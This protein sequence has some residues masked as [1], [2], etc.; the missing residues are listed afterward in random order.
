MVQNKGLNR[1]YSLKEKETKAILK[2]AST[3]LGKINLTSFIK[4]LEIARISSEDEVYILDG[5]PVFIGSKGEVLP[6]LLNKEILSKLPTITVDMGAVPYLCNG[7]DLMAPGIVKI[8]GEFQV[9]ALVV[10]VDENFS[11]PLALVK[12]LYNVDEIL[13]KKQ[14]KVARNIHFVGDRFWKKFRLA[15]K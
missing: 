6:T 14:G 8:S 9:G 10:V 7:A 13:V 5:T 2:K 3:I 12:A 11:K 15:K 4:G 1:K